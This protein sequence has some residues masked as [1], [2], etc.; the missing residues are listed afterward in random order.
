MANR[1]LAA[2]RALCNWAVSEDFLASSPCD[3]LR[4]PAAERSRERVL[5][6]AEIVAFWRACEASSWPFGPLGQL[7]LLTGARRDEIGAMTWSEIDLERAEWRLS[8][9]R[10]KNSREF[11]LPLTP[12]AVDILRS[13]PRITGLGD[14]VFTTNGRTPVSGFS[15]A[16]ERFDEE[17]AK[18][19][20][21]PP[22]PWVLHDL[23][24]TCASGL[25]ALGV[26]PH[27]IEA[28]LNHASGQIKG[29]AKVYNRHQY[30][31]EKREALTKWASYV[32]G[33]VGGKDEEAASSVSVAG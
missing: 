4:P 33:I 19:L 11:T 5:G 8:G 15:R 32:A 25:A 28:V 16:K 31:E 22:D 9:N 29:V 12:M 13:L 20:H 30:A 1:V 17:M 27:V 26:Q 2:V 7:L 24:R 3:K 10:V 14:F 6:E 23:R 18:S 21:E